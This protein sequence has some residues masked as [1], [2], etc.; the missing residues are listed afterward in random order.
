M[1]AGRSCS[2]ATMAGVS[3]WL[4]RSSTCGRGGV[5][6]REDSAMGRARDDKEARQASTTTAETD[7]G[8]FADSPWVA[9]GMHKASTEQPA[10]RL[11]RLALGLRRA[12]VDLV[13]N[14]IIPPAALRAQT[15]L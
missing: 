2:S 12:P 15:I 4:Q 10:S 13:G 3:P 5:S 1:P 8:R 11:S 14:A 7:R 6:V 9:A